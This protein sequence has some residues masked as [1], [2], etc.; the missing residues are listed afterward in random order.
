MFQ[1]FVFQKN[2]SSLLFLDCRWTES[3]FIGRY[4]PYKWTYSSTGNLDLF[5]FPCGNSNS[6]FLLH[7]YIFLYILRSF[8]AH[9]IMF[10]LWQQ[11]PTRHF[12]LWGIKS[13]FYRSLFLISAPVKR[14]Y[15]VVSNHCAHPLCF[16][17]Q[18]WTYI[19]SCWCQEQKQKDWKRYPWMKP[20]NLWSY[21]QFVTN[22]FI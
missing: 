14:Y 7:F 15:D 18:G 19:L 8:L 6:H 5:N 12:E 11:Q 4:C 13:T 17:F 20:R 2:Q 3:G 22:F 9:S 10:T 16:W 21:R 1:F